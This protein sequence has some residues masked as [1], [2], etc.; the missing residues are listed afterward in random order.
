MWLHTFAIVELKFQISMFSGLMVFL[1][2][3]CQKHPRFALLRDRKTHGVP[4]ALTR[5]S[6]TIPG[7]PQVARFERIR[8]L[9]FVPGSG[10]SSLPSGGQ[11]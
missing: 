3:V 10:A 4:A 5:Q 6:R 7:I 9:A 8:R 2:N 1:T 11:G